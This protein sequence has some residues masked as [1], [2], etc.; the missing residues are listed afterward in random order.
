MLRA[1]RDRVLATRGDVV[2]AVSID[3][4]DGTAHLLHTGAA[5]R[6]RLVPAALLP[7]VTAQEVP[8]GRDAWIRSA[9][10]VGPGRSL[11]IAA[12]GR[13]NQEG[14]LTADLVLVQ[15]P[16]R[17]RVETGPGPGEAV[18]TWPI[19]PLGSAPLLAGLA[20]PDVD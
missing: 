5:S 7:F 2:G 17:L 9:H 18:V 10:P 13:L 6:E 16:H 12:R 14:R 3:D 4:D 20:T 19:V 11:E 1:W 8:V 15:T